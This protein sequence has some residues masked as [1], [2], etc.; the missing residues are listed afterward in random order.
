[1]L[2]TLARTSPLRQI[3]WA[4]LGLLP[5]LGLKAAALRLLGPGPGR[6]WRRCSSAWPRGC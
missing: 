4:L 2:L 6:R 5:L 3:S 1:M